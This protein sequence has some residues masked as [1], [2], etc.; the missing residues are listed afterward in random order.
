MLNPFDLLRSVLEIDQIKTGLKTNPSVETEKSKGEIYICKNSQWI[1]NY[2]CSL[3]SKRQS[4]KEIKQNFHKGQTTYI[5]ATTFSDLQG[6][7]T[8]KVTL[9]PY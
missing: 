7:W 4:D 3:T 6:S 8:S 5:T 2:E 9:L 1:V